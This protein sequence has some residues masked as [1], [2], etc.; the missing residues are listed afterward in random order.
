LCLSGSPRFFEDEI[1]H[2][3][4]VPAPLNIIFIL[5][6]TKEIKRLAHEAFAGAGSHDFH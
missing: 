6:K 2:Q 1:V 4:G 3:F 5:I